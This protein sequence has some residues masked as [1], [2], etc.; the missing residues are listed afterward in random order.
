MLKAITQCTHATNLRQLTLGGFGRRTKSRNAHDVLGSATATAFLATA[1]NQIAEF[2]AVADNH[3]AH[4]LWSTQLVGR[5]AHGIDAE[6][7]HLQR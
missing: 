5:Y 4:T 6:R 3:R 2:G 1:G 7:G